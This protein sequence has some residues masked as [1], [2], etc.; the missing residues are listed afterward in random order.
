[1]IKYSNDILNHRLTW[2][3]TFQGLLLAALAFAWKDAFRMAYVLCFLGFFVAVSIGIGTYRANQAIE[4]LERK[5]D[6][7]T[8]KQNSELATIGLRSRTGWTWWLMPGYF[9][10]WLFA[11]GWLAITAM[12]F[13]RTD[14]RTQPHPTLFELIQHSHRVFAIDELHLVG[15]EYARFL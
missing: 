7:L 13:F 4:E 3:G 10:P 8:H 2:L 5:Y 9:V 15:I 1:M 6:G 14:V 12:T 11:V